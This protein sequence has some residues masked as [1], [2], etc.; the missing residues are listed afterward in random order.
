MPS[1]TVNEETKINAKVFLW[2]IGYMVVLVL[3]A[4][5]YG[6]NY[7]SLPAYIRNPLGSMPLSVVWFGA[8]GGVMVSLQ[9]IFMKSKEG[10]SAAWHAFSG[11]IGAVYGVFSYLALVLIIKASTNASS[12]VIN[13]VT[14]DLIAFVFGFSQ[15]QCQ[16]VLK[17]LSGLMF[18]QN[19]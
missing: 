11:V 14:F 16:V 3:L 15:R 17:R 2:P 7:K 12:V 19:D 4:L 6:A 8:I 5:L 1:P 10:S 18:G 13:T 9:S